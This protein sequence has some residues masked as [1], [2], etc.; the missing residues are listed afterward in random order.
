M[1]ERLVVHASK[2][3]SL[4]EAIGDSPDAAFFFFLFFLTCCMGSIA[5]DAYANPS[6]AG[7]PA[8]CAMQAG[9]RYIERVQQWVYI[10]ISDVR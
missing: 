2:S 3:G 5:A 6:S 10:A 8:A 4:H 7:L 1:L 9:G